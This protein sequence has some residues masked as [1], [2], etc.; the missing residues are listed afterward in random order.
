MGNASF[1]FGLGASVLTGLAVL[2]DVA[3]LGKLCLAALTSTYPDFV[4]TV[5]GILGC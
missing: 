5:A 1:T 2:I 3:A 4:A